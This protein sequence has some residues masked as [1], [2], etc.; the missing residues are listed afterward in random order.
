MSLAQAA[1][2]SGV[3][4]KREDT[5]AWEGT[6][7]TLWAAGADALSLSCDGTPVVAVAVGNLPLGVTLSE[8]DRPH[9]EACAA[10]VLRIADEGS[11]KTGAEVHCAGE[12]G[13]LPPR[14]RWK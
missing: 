11:L 12:I 5:S 4:R 9:M 3:R 2:G 8:E 10:C 14:D 1:L 13:S 7:P 6:P